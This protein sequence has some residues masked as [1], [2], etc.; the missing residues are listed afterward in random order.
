MS[1]G[2]EGYIIEYTVVGSSMKVTAFDPHS[3]TEATIIA[4]PNTPREEAAKL[5]IRKLHYVLRNKDTSE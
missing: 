1:T 3:L 2:D 4:T 5:A